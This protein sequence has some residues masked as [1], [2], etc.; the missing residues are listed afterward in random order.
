VRSPGSI[1]VPN[2]PGSYYN[3]GVVDGTEVGTLS[4]GAVFTITG[5]FH[6]NDPTNWPATGSTSS[7]GNGGKTLNANCVITPPAGTI[8]SGCLRLTRSWEAEYFTP[9]YTDNIT[10]W[11]WS[12]IGVDHSTAPDAGTSAGRW[13]NFYNGDSGDILDVD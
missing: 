11:G 12:Y 9:G 6:A 2:S 1:P 5:T 3:G 8:N 7:S 13:N 10:V 4:G